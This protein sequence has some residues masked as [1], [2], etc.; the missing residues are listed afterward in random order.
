MTKLICEIGWN[1][2]GKIKLA[3]KMIV[4][5]KENGADFVKFQNFN[6]KNLMPG[7]WDFDGRREL[8]TKSQMTLK[9]QN[10]LYKFCKKININFFS[11]VSSINDAKMLLKTQNRYVKIPSM[12]SRNLKLITFCSKKFKKVF[13]STG[14]SKLNEIKKSIKIIPKKKLILLHCVSSY[15]CDLVNANLPKINLLKKIT[16]DVGFSDHTIGLTA[17]LVSLN[18]KIKYIEKHFTIDQNLPGRDNKFAILPFELKIL[19]NFIQNWKKTIKN[20]GNNFLK[21]E[22]EVRYKYS[23]R[24][25]KND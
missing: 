5:A 2:L 16:K 19:S 7:P 11:S 4:A 10:I 3:K 8:Y 15:P 14:T 17:S 12:E 22:E 21:C 18:F 9:K 20:H 6:V 13:L 24:W 23:G 1:H 25:S